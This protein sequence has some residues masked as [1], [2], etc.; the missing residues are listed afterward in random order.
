MTDIAQHL[1]D[2]LAGCGLTVTIIITSLV[3]AGVDHWGRRRRVLATTHPLVIR[4]RNQSINTR[5]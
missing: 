2:F 4:S 1:S 5:L 3:W